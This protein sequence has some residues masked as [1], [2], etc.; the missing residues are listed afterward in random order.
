MSYR[1]SV[2]RIDLDISDGL[3][4][5]ISPPV[6][7][8]SFFPAGLYFEKNSAD[9]LQI[10][11][12]ARNNTNKTIHYYTTTYFMFNAVGDFAYDRWGKNYFKRKTVGPVHNGEILIDWTDKYEVE[13]YDM[14]CSLVFLHTIDLEYSDGT[15]ETIYYSHTGFGY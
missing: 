11:W 7:Y 5:K 15:C 8:S 10:R 12:T 3:N 14:S 4:Y 9:G 2:R 13:V 6:K 1:D